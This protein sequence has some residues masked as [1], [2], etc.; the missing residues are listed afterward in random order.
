[1]GLGGGG[2]AGVPPAGLSP[3]QAEQSNQGKALVNRFFAEGA[4]VATEASNLARGG[5]LVKGMKQ[6]DAATNPVNQNVMPGIMARE[7]ARFGV[8]ADPAQQ[9]AMQQQQ[10]LAAASSGVRVRNAAR[11]G[12]VNAEQDMR[13]GG[14]AA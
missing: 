12:L 14:G 5:L 7:S 4:P 13:F 1:M 2:G 3:L 10:A 8:Q 6:V 11:A 9:A